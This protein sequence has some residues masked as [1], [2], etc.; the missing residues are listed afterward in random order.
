VTVYDYIWTAED[1]LAGSAVP[2]DPPREAEPPPEGETSTH[3][4]VYTLYLSGQKQRYRH[5]LRQPDGAIVEAGTSSSRDAGGTLFHPLV[6]G[7][8][9]TDAQHRRESTMPFPFPSQR[10]PPLY[11][12][13]TNPPLNI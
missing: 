10:G 13:K 3:V 5:F 12:F 4:A 6:E 11:I 2:N 1:P 9:N 7:S 8:D